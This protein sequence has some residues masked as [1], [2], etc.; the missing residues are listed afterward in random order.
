MRANK[1]TVQNG[2]DLSEKGKPPKKAANAHPVAKSRPDSGRAPLT[3]SEWLRTLPPG[4]EITSVTL[5]KK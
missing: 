2:C 5:P 4:S 3:L 1:V